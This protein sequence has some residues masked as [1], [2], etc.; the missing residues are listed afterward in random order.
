MAIRERWRLSES[1]V[2]FPP[3]VDYFTY[4]LYFDETTD[5]EA[6]PSRVTVGATVKVGLSM[7]NQ[8]LSS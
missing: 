4:G 2:N 5:W 1:V 6:A 3:Q 8:E 7:L